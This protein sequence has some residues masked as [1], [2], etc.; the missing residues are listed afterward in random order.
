MSLHASSHG[1]WES[2][3][4]ESLG[5]LGSIL[6]EYSGPRLEPQAGHLCTV[7]QLPVHPSTVLPGYGQPSLP[8]EFPL[9]SACRATKGK[10]E[11][12]KKAE[13]TFFLLLIVIAV[14]QVTKVTED[15][16]SASF[17]LLHSLPA[18]AEV[19]HSELLAS[20]S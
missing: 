6:S 17:S 14:T 15:G 5:H 11:G 19:P 10:Q 3:H 18:P 2:L 16:H 4:L 1:N 8:D 7:S 13:W 20:V 12:T 9:T